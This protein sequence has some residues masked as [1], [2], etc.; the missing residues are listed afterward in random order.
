MDA[1]Q[2]PYGPG[3][4]SYKRRDT[5]SG[6]SGFCGTPT[7]PLSH[8]I[9][10]AWILLQ[11]LAHAAWELDVGLLYSLTSPLLA[12]TPSRAV[13]DRSQRPLTEVSLGRPLLPKDG[14]TPMS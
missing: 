7:S 4:K 9:C 1:M 11:H 12:Y 14:S 2:P 3:A 6:L 13:P 10:G 8:G 5:V